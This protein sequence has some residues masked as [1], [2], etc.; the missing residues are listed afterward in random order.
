MH[1]LLRRAGTFFGQTLNRHQA[2]G[3]LLVESRY[4]PGFQ[5]PR[6]AHERAFCYVVVEGSGAQTC[7]NRT[8]SCR[9]SEVIFHPAGDMHSNRWHETGGRCL[10]LEFEARWLDRVRQCAPVLDRPAKFRGGMPA[11]LAA[12]L[13]RELQAPDDFFAMAIEG[14]ALELVAWAARDSIGVRGARPP[15][16]L[17]RVKHLIE[18]RFQEPL[19]LVD[20]AREAGVHPVHLVTVFRRYLH[21]TPF[22]FVRRLRV[23]FVAE[24][25]VHGETCLVEIALRAGFTQ[26]SHFCRVFKNVTGLTPSAYRQLFGPGS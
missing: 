23:N 25:L 9:T 20:L 14:L 26:Q 10:H 16:W 18:A 21:C 1:P 24:Q 3:L 12:R 11:W 6:H 2:N 4:E 5:S 13:Y 19:T 7:G 15:G 17:R 22:D 8:R